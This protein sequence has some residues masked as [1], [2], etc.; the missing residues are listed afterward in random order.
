MQK[1]HNFCSETLGGFYL[2]VIKD[3]QY[4]TQA[5]S[6]ARRSCQTAMYHVTEAMTRWIA[7]ILSFTADEV[8]ENMPGQRDDLG[9]FTAEWYDGLFAYSNTEIDAST[10]ESVEQLRAEVMRNLET[11]RQDGKIGSS[12][13][14]DVTIL[15]DQVLI[16]QLQVLSDELRFVLITS[17]ATLAPLN[18]VESDEIITL[19]NGS[20]ILV[21]AAPSEHQKCVRC[22]HHRE[23][24]GSNAEHPGL[25]GRCIV[26]I[27]GDGEQ[28]RFA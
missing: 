24:I 2:D 1:I 16:D 6:L 12:L 10:W 23:E 26:N 18:G 11:L 27:D 7:P 19:R 3:R 22:W 14:A 5:D 13:D 21:Q 4:T 8:W 20:R 28:R 15:A 9:V 25:C 17:A